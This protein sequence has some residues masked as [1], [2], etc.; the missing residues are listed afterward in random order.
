MESNRFSR[1][2]FTISATTAAALFAAYKSV[3]TAFAA[4]GADYPELLL[5]TTEFHF[6][7]PAE[8]DAGL[9]RLT[10]DNQ[11]KEGH[12]AIFF[13]V[14]DDSTPD[15]FQA[16]LMAGDLGGVLAVSTAYGGHSADTGL[17]ASVI[18]HLNPGMYFVVCVIPDEQ[19]IPH[20]AHGMVAPLQ[21]SDTEVAAEAPT[22]SADIKLID[23]GFDGMPAT[24]TAG[25]NVWMV[26]NNGPQLHEML[27]LKLAEGVTADALLDMMSAP[28]PAGTPEASP[29]GPPPFAIVGGAAPMSVDAVNYLE[30]DLEAGS[31]AAICFVPDAESGM[32]HFMMGMFQGFEVA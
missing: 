31:Y 8:T 16:A 29:A 9:H 26:T 32:P 28:P 4:Q 14:N 27:V 25:A 2:T 18:A 11:G 5:V 17:S 12:H 21:V 22:A 7:M 19:G 13:R 6:D 24:A 15:D 3:P 23:Y 10:M 20:A 30:L 1:R